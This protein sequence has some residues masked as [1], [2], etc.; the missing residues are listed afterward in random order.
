MIF[1][2]AMTSPDEAFRSWVLQHYPTLAH[3]HW[4]RTYSDCTSG[5]KDFK[6]PW[7][8]LLSIHKVVSSRNPKNSGSFRGLL[9]PPVSKDCM[10]P[11]R[12]SYILL[13][14][15][16][17]KISVFKWFSLSWLKRSLIYCYGCYKCVPSFLQH[18]IDLPYYKVSEI[19]D[20]TRLI[21]MVEKNRPF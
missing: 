5:F 11:P 20:F 13:I 21:L 19:A 6:C 3:G 9:S 14:Q 12:L 2:R 15:Q 8:W 4:G 16:L 17:S 18:K 10:T 7:L 1:I